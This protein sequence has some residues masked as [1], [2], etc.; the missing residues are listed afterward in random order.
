L[1]AEASYGLVVARGT[2]LVW[3]GVRHGLTRFPAKYG[4]GAPRALCAQEIFS[5]HMWTLLVTSMTCCPALVERRL[6][7]E[8]WGSSIP[9]LT[10]V[11]GPCLIASVTSRQGLSR[12]ESRNIGFSRRGPLYGPPRHR[13]TGFCAAVGKRGANCVPRAAKAIEYASAR[14]CGAYFPGRGWHCWI[15]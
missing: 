12:E 10:K 7:G 11:G 13:T 5:A 14:A 4:S 2:L 6:P 15:N 9:V 3:P 8:A 1:A